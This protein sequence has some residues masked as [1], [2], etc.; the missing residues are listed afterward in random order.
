MGVELQLHSFLTS[1]LDQLHAPASLTPVRIEYWAGWPPEQ[2]DIL[3]K[4]KFSRPC[5]DPNVRSISPKTGR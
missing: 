1:A 3:K 4:K 5:R 2:A